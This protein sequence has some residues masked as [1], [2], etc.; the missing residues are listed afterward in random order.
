LSFFV[1]VLIQSVCSLLSFCVVS[2]CL[3]VSQ[4]CISIFVCF[5]LSFCLKC[6]SV[7]LSVRL[8]LSLSFYL[9]VCHCYP[10][11]QKTLVSNC[12][13]WCIS[14]IGVMKLVLFPMKFTFVYLF[15]CL[16]VFMFVCLFFCLRICGSVCLFVCCCLQWIHLC[17]LASSTL[18]YFPIF[19]EIHLNDAIKTFWLWLTKDVNCCV[20]NWHPRNHHH[21]LLLCFSD[22]FKSRFN[23]YSELHCVRSWPINDLK[24][25]AFFID[26]F[27]LMELHNKTISIEM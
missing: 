10:C 4:C 18:N 23:S 19:S 20:N 11:K 16:F 5:L 24:Q 13:R 14:A 22:S 25:I 26:R 7:C 12:V 2:V 21:W 17:L 8:S 15:V 9:F 3:S 1:W 6:L 27:R